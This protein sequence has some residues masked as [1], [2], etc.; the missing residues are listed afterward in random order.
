MW[1]NL[2][3]SAWICSFF[4][5]SR[6][7]IS[8]KLEKFLGLSSNVFLLL[9]LTWVL[10]HNFLTFLLALNCFMKWTELLNYCPFI[11]ISLEL[12]YFFNLQIESFWVICFYILVILVW[13]SFVWVIFVWVLIGMFS[14]YTLNMIHISLFDSNY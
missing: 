8:L 10:R 4:I 12:W 3:L 5:Q 7:Y 11:A 13:V 6:W 1:I 14:Y 2:W 9:W